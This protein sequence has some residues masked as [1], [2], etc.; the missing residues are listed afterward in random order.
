MQE[1]KRIS[2]SICNDN[3]QPDSELLAWDKWIQ[4]RKGE[5][6]YL[7]KKLG[8]QPRDLVMNVGENVRKER[9]QKILLENAQIQK[10][11]TIRNDV[12]W[13][14]PARLNQKCRCRPVYEA[15]RTKAELG[16][17]LVIERVGV[18]KILQETEK[19]LTGISKKK[20]FLKLDAAYVQ[21]KKRREK[22]LQN[23]IKKL[24]PYRPEVD[25][26]ILIGTKP[27]FLKKDLSSVPVLKLE[28]SIPSDICEES[29]VYAVQIN[30]SIY[31]KCYQGV[32]LKHLAN[33]QKQIT[34]QSSWTYYFNITVNKMGR[35]KL[36]LKNMGT[37]SLRYSWKK[38]VRPIEF[39]PNTNNELVFFFNKSD[40]I[41]YP[42]EEKHIL[43]TCL[44]NRAAFYNES[45]EMK[46]RNVSFLE[47]Q[48]DKF[49]IKLNADVTE[50]LDLIKRKVNKIKN[51]I[52]HRAATIMIKLLIDGMVTKATD[53]EHHIY[54]YK[55]LLLEA[56]M[57][58]MKNPEYFYHETKVAKLKQ[59]YIDMTSNTWELSIKDWRRDM[60]K[61]EY[62]NRMKYYDLLKQSCKELLRPW[63]EN[64]DILQQKYKAVKTVLYRF[65]D[66]FDGEYYDLI[67][68]YDPSNI[69]K[70]G[71]INAT[72]SYLK[73]Q[74]P[75]V[76][77][78]NVYHV[79]YIFNLR[80]YGHMCSMIE[81]CV[82]IIS[83]IDLNRRISFDFCS[84]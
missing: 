25:N 30:E 20:P 42:G 6:K 58:E 17:P 78:D 49:E 9:E 59:L 1:T 35:A 5:T 32:G 66:K 27:G 45:W 39:I 48:N 73:K 46:F 74:K 41:I 70:R 76:N 52:E 16:K 21:Y 81:T 80:M 71:E 44:S 11:V 14:D 13:E 75:K 38:I 4:I 63:R 40:D 24:N 60:M 37:V 61:L 18:P 57:F 3:V 15:Q 43:F 29:S 62:D 33:I 34:L 65:A 22:E 55:Y 83:S 10:K 84:E 23:K 8:R 7:A 28:T 82:G 67:K 72:F 19:G 36:F 50:N 68:E 54:P 2:R 69:A 53:L 31:Y 77:V 47:S 12:V 79:H 26:L 64:E 51:S 56:E